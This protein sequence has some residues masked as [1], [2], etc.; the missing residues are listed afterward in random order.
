MKAQCKKKLLLGA[1]CV[2]LNIFATIPHA[3]AQTTRPCPGTESRPVACRD[4]KG[5][6]VADSYCTRVG[7]KPTSTR[8]CTARCAVEEDWD[9]GGDG[10]GDP[11]IFDLDGNGISLFKRR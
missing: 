4:Y 11:L 2:A 3:I 5:N 7:M 1:S 9:M 10:S 6:A 8:S